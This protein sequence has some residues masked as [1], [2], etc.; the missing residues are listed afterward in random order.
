MKCPMLI[1][2]PTI[3]FRFFFL[4]LR[5][6]WLYE[7]ERVDTVAVWCVFTMFNYLTKYRRGETKTNIICFMKMHGWYVYLYSDTP[8]MCARQRKSICLLR[9]LRILK[10][11]IKHYTIS[12][13]AFVMMMILCVYGVVDICVC[14]LYIWIRN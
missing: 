5:A 7:R 6:F 8:K 1:L 10:S 9:H 4:T 12:V 2:I 14:K 13:R 3:I 11:I